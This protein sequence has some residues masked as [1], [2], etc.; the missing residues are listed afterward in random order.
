MTETGLG[1]GGE[2]VNFL[3][4]KAKREKS[5]PPAHD[6]MP[7]V[8]SEQIGKAYDAKY[9]SIA[10]LAMRD[11]GM[12]ETGNDIE[13]MQAKAYAEHLDRPGVVSAL[14][15]YDANPKGFRERYGDARVRALSR[16]AQAEFPA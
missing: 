16:R 12:D 8:Y 4:E 1:Q 11:V 10:V 9:R 6:P 13:T 5:A 7:L 3:A 14:E 15:S 2:V